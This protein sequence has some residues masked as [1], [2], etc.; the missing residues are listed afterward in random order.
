MPSRRTSRATQ[1]TP[2]TRLRDYLLVIGIVL[3]L[4]FGALGFT[5]WQQ[6]RLARERGIDP[7]LLMP[8]QTLA[9]SAGGILAFGCYLGWVMLFLTRLRPWLAEW[10]GE[11]LGVT[12]RERGKGGWSV[13]PSSGLGLALLV[14]LADISLLLLGTM[15]PFALGLTA[16]FLLLER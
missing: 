7:A 5:W 13:E 15:G 1:P 9:L 12:I 14:A 2:G 11:R 16:L 8:P 10:L 3:A 4:G 6:W